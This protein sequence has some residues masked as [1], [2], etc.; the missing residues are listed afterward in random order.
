MRNQGCQELTLSSL[1]I[2]A[3]CLEAV[4]MDFTVYIPPE[5]MTWTEARLY[6]QRNHT[7]LVTGNIV[8][9]DLLANWLE[10]VDVKK[11]WIG[12]HRD[13]EKD[14]AWKWINVKTGEGVSGHDL[15]Q[16]GNWAGEKQ[17]SQCAAVEDDLLW[18]SV[19]C[20]NEYNV[21]CS[22]GDKIL[23][24]NVVLSWYK[25]IQYCQNNMS[26]LATI[27]NTNKDYLKSSGW[28][29]LY[30]KAGGSWSW[31]GDSSS[32]YRN[33]APRE[34]RAADCGSL[35][36]VPNKWNS[37]VCS[38]ELHFVCYEDD[39]VVVNENKTWEEAMTHCKRMNTPCVDAPE[40]CIYKNEILNL[41][42]LQ[43][44]S[45]VRDR[46][47]RATTD[48]VWTGLRFL[49]GEWWWM[50]GKEPQSQGILPECPSH[51]NH[52][53]TL[54]KYDT[55]NWITRDCSERRNFLCFRR[56]KPLM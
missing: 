2:A 7:D 41:E 50:N 38:R 49:G 51:R 48:E 25:A 17:S 24:H 3:L 42:K 43:D 14:S 13:P 40:T 35:N 20:S 54:S 19:N 18:Y 26:D 37:E 5:R 10:T 30:H 29:G 47:Y 46:I 9:T 56:K 8:E 23:H 4:L 53:G 33:W 11:L 28:I 31:I 15:S 32:D 1:L 34:P 55:N 21:Y 52:C 16:S 27:T 44:Y 12:L 36:P 39:L 45:Y 6:C 22:A